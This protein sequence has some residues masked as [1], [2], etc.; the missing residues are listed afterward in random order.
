MTLQVGVMVK[1]SDRRIK[2]TR[3]L[4]QGLKSGWEYTIEYRAI[5]HQVLYC[6]VCTCPTS[7]HL[8]KQQ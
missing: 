6:V 1:H 4:A 5:L 7:A 2:L 3:N 8:V